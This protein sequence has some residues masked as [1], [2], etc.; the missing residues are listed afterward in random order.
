MLRHLP[1][2]KQ[3]GEKQALQDTAKSLIATKIQA[4]VTQALQAF[5]LT[6]LTVLQG[7][8]QLRYIH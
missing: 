4:E 2:T 5:L 3:K 8:N 1:L 6:L 7:P